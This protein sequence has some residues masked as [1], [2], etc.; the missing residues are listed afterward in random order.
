MLWE[1]WGYEAQISGRGTQQSRQSVRNI[2]KSYLEIDVIDVRAHIQI[3]GCLHSRIS[4]SNG[5][6][7]AIQRLDLPHPPGAIR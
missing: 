5:H 1:T 3:R 6:A 4:V 7:H 2:S